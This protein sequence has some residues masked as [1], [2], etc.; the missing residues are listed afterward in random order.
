M[1]H[2]QFSCLPDSWRISGAKLTP[3]CSSAQTADTARRRIR[4]EVQKAF[5][6]GVQR[7]IF[8]GLA[9][10]SCATPSRSRNIGPSQRRLARLFLF[11]HSDLKKDRPATTSTSI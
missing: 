4:L 3:R 1:Y 6:R 11:G 8:T 2:V 10:V 9:I 5:M 7:Q